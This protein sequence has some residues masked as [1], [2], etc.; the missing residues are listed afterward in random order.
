MSW[1]FSVNRPV[2][3]RRSLRVIS[4]V[5]QETRPCQNLNS[6]WSWIR[7]SNPDP[8]VLR[9]DTSERVVIRPYISGKTFQEFR[10]FVYKFEF[11]W[12]ADCYCIMIRRAI[13]V[14][15]EKSKETIFPILFS[16]MNFFSFIENSEMH[17]LKNKVFDVFKLI[18][19]D[20]ITRKRNFLTKNISYQSRNLQLL[21]ELLNKER[22]SIMWVN[23]LILE[24]IFKN[25]EHFIG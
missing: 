19:N 13:S 22:F 4:A 7:Q 25:L 10:C 5:T 20:K 21:N 24:T 1:A 6:Q 2:Y 17:V 15:F 11:V 16:I 8:L 14:I 12:I 23:G 9:N 3:L 18:K